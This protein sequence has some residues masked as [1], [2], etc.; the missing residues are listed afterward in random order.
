ML[1]IGKMGAGQEGY[2][3][4]KVA[5]GAEDYY[6]GEGEAEGYWLVDALGLARY[7]RPRLFAALML[8]A[9]IFFP[10]PSYGLIEAAA[11]RRAQEITSLLGDAVFPERKRRAAVHRGDLT[12]APLSGGAG[13]HRP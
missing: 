2:Y 11:Q 5:E 8:A 10:K 6:S 3:L 12:G 1:S 4:G 13:H 7:F 9:L